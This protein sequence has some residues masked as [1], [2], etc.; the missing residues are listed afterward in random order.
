MKCTY[1]GGIE[2]FEGPSGGMSVNV[3][4]A[5]PKCRH[6]FNTFNGKIIEDL[7][8]IAPT[9]EEK[10]EELWEKTRREGCALYEEG[11]PA[12]ACIKNKDFNQYGFHGAAGDDIVRLA[13][14]MDAMSDRGG[15]R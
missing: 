7:N 4:C 15:P 10:A 3:L 11:R 12:S 13:G 6:W 14:W 9:K 8:L 5:D 1:C 2:F